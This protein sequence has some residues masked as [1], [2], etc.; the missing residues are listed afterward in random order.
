MVVNE[1]ISFE[2]TYDATSFPGETPDTPTMTLE[3]MTSQPGSTIKP[4]ALRDFPLFAD[5]SDREL[6]Q[7][8]RLMRCWNLL[9]GTV[10]VSEGGPGGGCFIIVSGSVDVTVRVRGRQQLLARL[11]A[12]RI[13]GQVS[14]ISGEARSATCSMSNDGIILELKRKPCEALL[15]AGSKT[16]LKFLAALNQDLMNALRRADQRLLQRCATGRAACAV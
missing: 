16:A 5:F 7:L 12:G 10:V 4:D 1:Q 11:P 3:R 13:F 14:L 9:R 6:L 8:L 2:F 15:S